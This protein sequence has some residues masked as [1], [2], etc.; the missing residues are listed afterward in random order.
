M[1][2][3]NVSITNADNRVAGAGAIWKFDAPRDML[4]PNSRTLER[5]LVFSF[6]GGVPERPSGYFDPGVRIYA[7]KR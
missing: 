2:L 5:V 1:G 4:E 6:Q 7:R 3:T